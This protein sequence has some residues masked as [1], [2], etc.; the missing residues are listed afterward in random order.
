M[1]IILR[2]KILSIIIIVVMF[3]SLG[4]AIFPRSYGQ[5]VFD[6][7]EVIEIREYEGEDLSSINDFRDKLQLKDPNMLMWKIIH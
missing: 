4:L 5:D 6:N 3:Y 7:S 1:I 2:L